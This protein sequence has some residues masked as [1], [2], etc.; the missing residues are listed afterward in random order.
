[1]KPYTV[2][3]WTTETEWLTARLT[4]IGSSDAAAVVGLGRDRGQYAVWAEKTSPLHQDNQFDELIYWGHALEDDIAERFLRDAGIDRWQLMD[5]GE[6]SLYRR[7]DKPWHICTPDRLIDKGKTWKPLELKTAHYDQAM[8]WGKEVPWPYIVQSQWQQHVLGADGGYIAVLC[9]GR[10]FAWH[11]VE[12]NEEIIRRLVKKV[13]RFWNENVL[14]KVA[15]PVDA[16]S[17]TSTWLGR[18][19]AEPQKEI[20]QLPEDFYRDGKR[21]DKIARLM[22][23]LD[24][25]KILIKNRVKEAMGNCELA[26]VGD[27]SGFQWAGTNGSRRFTRKEKLRYPD[28]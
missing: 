26:D 27:G 25:A 19:Y 13:D 8:I 9:N 2:E 16:T 5:P 12:R 6:Y 11:P 20:A 24:K 17:A 28:E 1:M 22:G 7:T 14:P 23:K 10:D 4:G 15:P 21:W 3:N 18:L